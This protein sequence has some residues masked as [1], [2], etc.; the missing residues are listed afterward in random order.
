MAGLSDYT[1][2]AQLNW[3]TGN[4]P[5]PALG[6]RYL[7]LFTAAPTADAGTGGTEVSGTG[8][9]RVQVAGNLAI[10]TAQGATGT[11]LTFASVPSWIVA[12]MS[13]T[14]TTHAYIAAGATVVSTTSTTVVLSAATTTAV[15]VSDNIVF[16]AWPAAAASSGTEPNT[17]PASATN[18]NATITF[19]QATASWGTVV[20]WGIY[21]AATSGNMMCWD[22]LGNFKW[23]P[24]TCTS[25]T[26]GV[27]TT[28]STTDAPANGNSIVVTSKFGGTLP[29][30]SGS[31]SGLLTTAGLQQHVQRWR[32]YDQHGRRSVPTGHATVNPGQRHG[33]FRQRYVD[34]QRGVMWRGQ[35]RWRCK[36]RQ[37]LSHLM[38][39][40]RCV[41][42]LLRRR[43][44]QAPP[45]P[46]CSLA[47]SRRRFCS[48]C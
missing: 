39:L 1:A 46:A 7:A 47:L 12:G 28:D 14:D 20:A 25:A 21:D 8:Y 15:P 4:S 10:G 26:P 23:V 17:T 22:Y 31:W 37:L 5:M 24:F 43:V 36:A 6:S 19:A 45:W 44:K 34:R 32:Q 30:T 38:R 27:M 42:L 11:T 48:R 9:A 16:S 40:H 18:T 2:Q 35:V 3:I 33:L 13:V 41:P 29:T